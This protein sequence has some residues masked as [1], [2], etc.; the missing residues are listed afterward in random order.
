MEQRDPQ[1]D[2]VDGDVGF[3]KDTFWPAVRDRTAAD[4]VLRQGFWTSL[5]VGTV[6]AGYQLAEGGVAAAVSLGVA[7][8][9]GACGVRRQSVA[10]ASLLMV[11]ETCFA[12]GYVA[13]NVRDGR[14]A[15][16]VL[17]VWAALIL[18]G[19]VRATALSLRYPLADQTELLDRPRDG[20]ALT[21]ANQVAPIIW[22]WAKIPF[23]LTA[24][25]TLWAAVVFAADAVMNQG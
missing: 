17:G 14:Y 22:R 1:P 16:P 2:P 10:A 11:I 25:L 7:F 8:L 24:A 4:R 20:W 21:L 18:I 19:N 6:H 9:L 3:L 13:I 23:F 5:L 12:I 15:V